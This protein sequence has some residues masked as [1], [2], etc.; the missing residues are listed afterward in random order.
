MHI[1]KKRTLIV[2]AI[3]AAGIAAYFIRRKNASRQRS[4]T[5]PSSAQ[6][7]R[8]TTDVFAKAKSAATGQQGTP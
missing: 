3:A 2:A 7:S 6:G 4:N 1:M 8:H 5:E